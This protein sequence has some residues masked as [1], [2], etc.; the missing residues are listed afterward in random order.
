MHSPGAEVIEEGPEWPSVLLPW[1]GFPSLGDPLVKICGWGH[2]L[3][4]PLRKLASHE[5][6]MTSVQSQGYSER[7]GTQ[8]LHLPTKAALQTAW[9]TIQVPNV[10][11]ARPSSSM[12]YST[13]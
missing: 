9:L 12:V 3:R 2:G 13:L 4:V 6:W 11:S 5:S 10:N 8:T 7:R 1:L